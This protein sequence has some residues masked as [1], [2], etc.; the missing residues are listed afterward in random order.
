MSRVRRIATGAALGAAAGLLIV[1]LGLEEATSYTGDNALLPIGA[2]LIGAL[3]WQTRVRALLAAGLALLAAV[4]LLV[5]LTP[6]TR[7]LARGMVRADVLAPADAVYVLAAYVQGDG[8]LGSAALSRLHHGAELVRAGWA[9]RL[10][11]SNVASRPL[12][13]AAAARALRELGL[14]IPLEALGPV[15]SNTHDEAREL[16]RL[17]RE[18]GWRR[19]ILVTSPLHTRRAAAVFERA[20]LEVIS[21]PA[22]ETSYD[23]ENLISG[24]DRLRAFG[25]ILHE[26]VGLLVYRWRGWI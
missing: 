21:S 19:V 24:D 12:H 16:A 15:V 4:W 17:A 23:V 25:P 9:P 2:A 7:L 10:L 22:S 18:R 11:V 20:G 6:V 1:D 14:A 26:R 13:A 5:V 3:L 8:E